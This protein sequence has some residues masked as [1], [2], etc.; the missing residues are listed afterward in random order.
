M[1][2]QVHEYDQQNP[3]QDL[4]GRLSG[5]KR[6]YGFFHRS[7]PKEP[8]V[9]LYT[10]LMPDITASLDDI[11]DNTGDSQATQIQSVMQSRLPQPRTKL[12]LHWS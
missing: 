10:A 7:M 4:K 2:A 12:E 5:N 6:L 11:L 8:L 1:D 9:L 3:W